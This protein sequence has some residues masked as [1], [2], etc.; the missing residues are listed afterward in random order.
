[1]DPHPA[2]KCPR[3]ASVLSCGQRCSGASGHSSICGS[4]L[5]ARGRIYPSLLKKRREKGGC[6]DVFKAWV[7]EA[8]NHR[9][10]Q[11]VAVRQNH[12]GVVRLDSHGLHVLPV[13]E[14]HVQQNR[15]GCGA[16][17][18][19]DGE[20]DDH[21]RDQP[22]GP[23]QLRLV[24]DRLLPQPPD[25][26]DRAVD[27]DDVRDDDLGEEDNLGG[28]KPTNQTIT[29]FYCV[30]ITIIIVISSSSK[31]T[32]SKQYLSEGVGHIVEIRLFLA[33]VAVTALKGRDHGGG[34]EGEQEDPDDHGYLRRLLKHF[35]TVSPSKMNH[36]EVAIE[37][38]GDEEGDAGSSIE[39]EHEEHYLAEHGVLAA[40]QAVP[41][42]VDLERKA[43]HQQEVSDH[44]IE[45]EDGFVPPEL[46]P[47]KWKQFIRQFIVSQ[48]HKMQVNESK[49][50]ALMLSSQT[51][52]K[53]SLC[54]L[55]SVM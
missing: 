23:P 17:Q 31:S 55:S 32:K 8:V 7:T 13:F 26:A 12:E 2:V 35:D 28:K 29:R 54:I 51:D 27:E 38:H 6:V 48:S 19:T 33:A 5:G 47:N 24:P 41:V 34:G 46:E 52:D 37:G 11:A 42:M 49:L 10:Q 9:V 40:P 43:A 30:I 25:G 36:A 39:E 20:D 4:V 44:Y 53:Y 22:H 18:E 3:D 1:M 21:R 14:P 16:G 50:L 15:S 45:Q